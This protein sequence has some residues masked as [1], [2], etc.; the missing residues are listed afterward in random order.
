MSVNIASDL[1]FTVELSGAVTC[2]KVRDSTVYI[3]RGIISD[4][5]NRVPRGT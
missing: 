5:P 4:H 1:T 3:K 2:I